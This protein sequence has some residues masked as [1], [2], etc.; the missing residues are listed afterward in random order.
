MSAKS[1]SNRVRLYSISK[2]ILDL[3][4]TVV[5]AVIST[6]I[7]VLIAFLL[8]LLQGKVLFRQV[9][10]G[11][12]GEPFILYKFCSMSDG[13]D[14]NGGLLPD[15]DRLTRIGSF[16][17]KTSLDE[18]PQLWNVLRGDMSLVGP[19]PLLMEYMPRY[20]TSQARRH[21]V[22][23]GITGWAQVNGRNELDWDTKFAFDVWYVDHKSLVLDIRIL[24]L[25]FINVL[26]RSGISNGR[27]ATMP[28]FMGSDSDL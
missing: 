22:K 16:L 24:W 1:R 20:T 19:R 27:H 6:P 25:T 7:S 14:P 21:E 3:S 28:E 26:R 4:I 15:A 12:N 18:L 11:R 10:P 17:R 23:P 8:W 5:V 13:R 2:R 9:R